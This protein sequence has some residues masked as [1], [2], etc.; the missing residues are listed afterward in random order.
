MWLFQTA[1]RV[2]RKQ[3]ILDENVSLSFE[4]LYRDAAGIAQ[5]LNSWGE[6]G[7]RV[8]IVMPS[9]VPSAVLNLGAMLAGQVAVPIDPLL[10]P[11]QLESMRRKIAP[12]WVFGPSTL[13]KI[14]DDPGLLTADTY[15]DLSQW[16][17]GAEHSELPA[18]PDDPSRLLSIVYTSG[19]T[20]EPKGVMLNG[21]NLEAVIHGIV[22]ALAL[23]ED[24]RIFSPLS[25]SHTYGLSQLWLMART[26]ATLAVVSDIMKVATIKKILIDQHI[27]TLAGV[28][29]HFT[30]LTRRGEKERLDS[31]RLVTIAG[32]APTRHLLQRVRMAYPKAR[33]HI[34]YGLTEAS[35]RLTTLP[36]EDLEKG[37]RC[38]G[39]PIDGVELKI[40]DEEGKELGPH[41]EGVL[42]ARGKNISP[43]Y[44]KDEELTR[45]TI[46]NGWLHT[47]DIVKK[48]ER[49]YFYFVGRKDLVFKS[50]GKKII[51][52][53][54]EGVLREMEGIRD[55]AVFGKR[56]EFLGNRI[57]AVVVR[58]KGSNLSP[59]VILSKCRNR[60]DRSWIPHEVSFV[61]TIP[62][63]SCGKVQYDALRRL[64][65]SKGHQE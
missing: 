5:W 60:L 58:K 54:I 51:P 1:S 64:E 48:D 16:I 23:G 57:C 56:D 49:G 20:G 18:H 45:R 52:S 34:L 65:D 43:G 3:A 22:A 47:G 26:G 19:T 24:C 41:E 12:R 35:T 37:E 44:W 40:V 53:V 36:S 17:S 4:A 32:E 38:I 6:A 28:P 14:W 15:E 62:K 7:Q 50:G 13:R 21:A 11:G 61:E 27:N 39:L 55:A 10:P 31:I 42:I 25:F 8:L 29:Y 63:S 59:E 33:I 30:V 9:S 46:V 2:P